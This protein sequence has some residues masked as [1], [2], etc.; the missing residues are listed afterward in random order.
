MEVAMAQKKVEGCF[1][2]GMPFWLRPGASHSNPDLQPGPRG[3]AQV[4]LPL[5]GGPGY[6]PCVWTW[7]E[8]VPL[9]LSRNLP[10]E[11]Q[12]GCA[13]IS[14]IKASLGDA[15]TQ[16]YFQRMPRQPELFVPAVHSPRWMCG[17]HSVNF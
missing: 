3:P 4:S 8:V 12:R 9:S 5:P 10:P 11:A 6:K 7:S 17:Y 13:K 14:L 15:T 2:K 16:G 1:S